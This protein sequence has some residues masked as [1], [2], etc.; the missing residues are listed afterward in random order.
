MSKVT[1]RIDLASKN[2]VILAL[3]YSVKKFNE[4]W[5]RRGAIQNAEKILQN[6]IKKKVYLAPCTH[7]FT[8]KWRNHK[9]CTCFVYGQFISPP[10]KKKRI[11]LSNQTT[12]YEKKWTHATTSDLHF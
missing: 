12:S 8:K 10:P 3:E 4:E 7:E 6:N 9:Y 11:H 2:Y 1:G 5:N